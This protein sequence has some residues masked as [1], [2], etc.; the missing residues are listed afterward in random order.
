MTVV[1]S[2]P[3]AVEGPAVSVPEP[4]AGPGTTTEVDP[5][6]R[7]EVSYPATRTA[8]IH[9]RGGADL[10]NTAR[11]H[12]LL[13]RRLPSELRTLVLDLSQLSFLSSSGLTA[14]AEAARSAEDHHTELRIIPGESRAVWTVLRATGLQHRL[15][16]RIN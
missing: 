15:P 3:R 8:V 13:H 10:S 16:L 6:L 1:S 4:R 11:L 7:L 12:E 14:I 2:P 5:P 9:A